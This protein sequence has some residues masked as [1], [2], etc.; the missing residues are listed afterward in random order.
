MNNWERT[1][2]FTNQLS[3]SDEMNDDDLIEAV[4]DIGFQKPSFRKN[5]NEFMQDN[6][7]AS[8]SFSNLTMIY[9]KS[10]SVPLLKEY[11]YGWSQNIPSLL[12]SGAFPGRLQDFPWEFEDKVGKIPVRAPIWVLEDV[13]NEIIHAVTDVTEIWMC[14]TNNHNMAILVVNKDGFY[15]I[16]GNS[17]EE[18]LDSNKCI[19]QRLEVLKNKYVHS[20]IITRIANIV[21]QGQYVT[22][23]H[24]DN[25]IPSP[26]DVAYAMFYFGNPDNDD[27]YYH[28]I[29]VYKDSDEFDESNGV[30]SYSLKR[31]SL[32]RGAPLILTSFLIRINS[33]WQAPRE[34]PILKR[35]YFA[36][37][38]RRWLTFLNATRTIAENAVEPG[39]L[40]FASA[41]GRLYGMSGYTPFP[42]YN[43]CMESDEYES[44]RHLL[45]F[46]QEF[47]KAKGLPPPEIGDDDEWRSRI[48]RDLTG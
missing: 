15:D 39:S 46:A 45:R 25:I 11:V 44:N 28:P 3:T 32:I 30:I 47:N 21:E 17:N 7:F 38:K 9:S 31:A 24:H 1:P 40:A 26:I 6:V 37:A 34:I 13:V 42:S 41:M 27:G 8:V 23:Y 43:D 22:D 16:F 10:T 19:L 5:F 12:R 20:S 36:F 35:M 4:Y 14:F 33:E 2:I 18:L 29:K 48:C